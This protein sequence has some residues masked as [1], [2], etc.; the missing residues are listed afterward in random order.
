MAYEIREQKI[1]KCSFCKEPG[2]NIKKCNDTRLLE[3]EH[4]CSMKVHKSMNLLD[5]TFWI[6]DEYSNNKH[7][8]KSYAVKKGL[9]KIKQR[10]IIMECCEVISRYICEIFKPEFL[11][12]GNV[13]VSL[14]SMILELADHFGNQSER[15][16]MPQFEMEDNINASRV[17]FELLMYNMFK[18]SSKLPSMYKISLN[19]ENNENEDPHELCEC[20]V[21]LD[22]NKLKDFIKFDCKHE[23]CKSCV[24]KLINTKK[25][26]DVDNSSTCPY[27]R[28]EIQNLICK[29]IAVRDQIR[30]DV[31]KT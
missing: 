1:C 6:S 27:C 23:F 31:F 19:I 8:L 29:D 12:E 7:L 20:G 17:M 5:F 30:S 13:D 2:H 4:K 18:H 26:S 22:N 3:F 15:V 16:V 11:V 14:E 25:S 9:L 28:V 24:I 21:C 10:P